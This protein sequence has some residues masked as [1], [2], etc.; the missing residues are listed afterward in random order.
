[1]L[2][3]TFF[4]EGTDYIKRFIIYI[5]ILFMSMAIGLAVDNTVSAKA[6]SNSDF[7]KAQGTSLRN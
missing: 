1:M 2:P 4:R 6:I 7:I 3:I 5:S